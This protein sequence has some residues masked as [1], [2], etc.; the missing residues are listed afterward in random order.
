MDE[1]EYENMNV[2]PIQSAAF[3]PYADPDDPTA[4]A[5]PPRKFEPEQPRKFEPEQPDYQNNETLERFRRERQGG[6]VRPAAPLPATPT[7]AVPDYQNQATMDRVARETLLARGS[8]SGSG[9]PSGTMGGAARLEDGA[10]YFG[11]TDRD[12]CDDLV[13]GGGEGAFVVRDSSSGRGYVLMVNENGE[14]VNY[15]IGRGV[16]CVC[17]PPLLTPP[18]RPHI[19]L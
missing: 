4:D 8:G 11:G 13:L 9:S 12:S 3:V 15:A 16:F 2:V 5:A 6:G 7:G 1:D 19:S 10:W 14:T 18:H 17:D